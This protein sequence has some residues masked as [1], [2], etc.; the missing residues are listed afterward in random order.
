MA[1]I[2]S[3]G[4]KGH[5]KFTLTVTENST[6]VADNTSSVS[7]SFAISPVQTSWNWEQWGANIT[8]TVTI[9]G[10]NYTGSIANYDG[11]STV[12]LKSDSLTVGHNTDGSKSISF[13]FSV[14]DT[15]GVN[16]TCGNASASGSMAL[17][18]I[19][20]YLSITSLYVLNITETSAVVSWSTS[21]P[22][23]ST[24]YSFDNGA[25]W[26]GSATDGEYLASDLKSGTFNIANLQANTAYNLKVKIK[27]TD[28][29]LWTE[30]QVVSFATHQYPHCIDS[31]DFTIGEPLTLKL[32]NPLG[33]AVRITGY[34]NSD[35]REIFNGTTSGN[36]ITG[37]NDPNSMN[38]QYLSIPNA[39]SGGYR[40][41]VGFDSVAMVRDSGNV[42]RIRGNEVPSINA[43]DYID[44]NSA[45]VAVTGDN[46]QIVQNKSMLQARFH[47]ATANYGAGGIQSYTLECNGI[48]IGGYDAG[49]YDVGVINSA[50]NVNLTLTAY[51]TRG[52]SASK[53]ITVNM[54]AY[55][56]PKATI[57]LQRL[58]NYEDE[59]YLTVDGSVSSVLNKNTMAIK[60]RYKQSGGNYGSFTNI[61]DRA[62]Q[63]L[64]LDKNNAYIFN[65][66]V[67]DIFGE[68]FDAEFVLNKGT[69]PL[70]IDTEK[71]SVGIN[72]FPK[73]EKSLEINGLLPPVATSYDKEISFDDVTGKLV[74]SGFYT[75][76]D[77]GKWYNLINIRHR[78]GEE[79]GQYY[80]TQIRNE[81]VTYTGKF[82][83]RNHHYEGWGQWRNLQ[84]EG[85]T[86][87][88]GS[89]NTRFA[90][91]D[92]VYNYNSVEIF[93]SLRTS[94]V[95]YFSSIKVDSPNG[96]KCSLI[97]T[98]GNSG[99]LIVGMAVVSFDGQFVN[100]EAN[101]TFGGS[102]LTYAT[103]NEVYIHKVLGYR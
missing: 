10:T 48:S 61:S 25:T 90:L 100:F 67:T 21:D 81:M 39:Q 12:T 28:S 38:L 49:A 20:R 4:S 102:P 6:S 99:Y 70:F 18:N 55:E 24:Y 65:V 27:R 3:N 73:Y 23:S 92:F 19:P 60:Y 52:L 43:F 85:I 41:I 31:P 35:N 34:A 13:S 14:S 103:S 44:S 40:V 37:F 87:F 2:S 5:H 74:R 56:A 88:E 76:N 16:Y 45:V 42:Y 63:T 1:S 54:V 36:T 47:S 58:N 93:Y 86:I 50:R 68:K 64:T 82:Q 22:R 89:S 59:T 17:S 9:N 32:Y 80:G 11:Y 33:R 29:G 62:K 84:E 94:G 71:N 30:S 57:Q 7:F 98:Q 91:T 46:T 79:D 83:V 69:F 15:S 75:V 97:S 77:N 95:D 53:T 101:N 96:K 72:C 51:D 66:V 8:Y 78:N 26:I